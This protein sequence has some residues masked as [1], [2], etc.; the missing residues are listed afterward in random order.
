[1]GAL[2]C[3]ALQSGLDSLIILIRHGQTEF[4]RDGRLQGRLDSPLTPLGAEQARRM[5]QVVKAWIDDPAAWS[6]VSSPLGR[7]LQTA[8]II[9]QEAALDGPIETDARLLEL[10]VGAFEGLTREEILCAAPETII[11][12]G[13]LYKTPGGED[14]GQLRAR[15]A[16][17]LAEWDEADGR[18]RVV[19]S[20]GIAGRM[21]RHL[22][23]GELLH[24][25]PPPQDA[26]FRLS[27][28]QIERIDLP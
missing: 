21:L 18:N 13:W 4:N 12:P 27:A 10:S 3:V 16:A 17:W 23:T 8:Q 5:G 22:Y 19:V 2:S 28:G 20:H 9:R 7:A 14:E 24:S 26:V 15:L 6:V 25:E 1:M 11:A